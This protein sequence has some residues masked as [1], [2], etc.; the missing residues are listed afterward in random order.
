M[1]RAV[2]EV[3]DR[4]LSRLVMVDIF[5]LKVHSEVVSLLKGR[6]RG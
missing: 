2:L 4:L 6:F 3:Q 1:E 5:S